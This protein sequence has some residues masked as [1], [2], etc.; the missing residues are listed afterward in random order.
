TPVPEFE[1][2]PGIWYSIIS[3][4]FDNDGDNDLV[5]GNIGENIRFRVSEKYPMNMYVLDFEMDG[6]VD[7]IMTSFWPDAKGDMKE[8]PVNY[9]DELWSQ[10][11]YLKAKLRNYT[12]F[13]AMEAKD[14]IPPKMAANAAKL[15]INT[16]ASCIIW[17]NGK[18]F[19]FQRLPVEMQ[20]S[21]VKKMIAADLNKDGYQDLI[22]GGNDYSYEVPTGNFDACKGIVLINRLSSGKREDRP[23][24]LL[25]PAQSGLLLQGM[26]ESMLW[27]EGDT[28]FIVAGFNRADAKLFVKSEYSVK[29]Q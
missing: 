23:F 17:N 16:V 27:F 9:L 3:G 20:L 25:G 6:I 12:T 4:D 24:E 7:P 22:A 1:A 29:K 10:S 14:L 11:P 8:Y 2:H 15:N 5:A 21:P 28:S 19:T 26:L 18:S 13:S